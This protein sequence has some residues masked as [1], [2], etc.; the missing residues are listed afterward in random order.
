MYTVKVLV[1]HRAINT[2]GVVIP[3]SISLPQALVLII[4]YNQT[5]DDF[6]QGRSQT[7]GR[8]KH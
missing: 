5:V 6:G 2:T 1:G 8:A 7:D 4:Q 3:S